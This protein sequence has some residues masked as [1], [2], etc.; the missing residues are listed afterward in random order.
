MA[1]RRTGNSNQADARE[2]EY[3]PFTQEAAARV[4]EEFGI[5]GK[6]DTLFKLVTETTHNYERYRRSPDHHQRKEALD[7]LRNAVGQAARVATK[8]ERTLVDSLE[9]NLLRRLGELL[10]YEGIEKLLGHYVGRQPVPPA[11]R[12]WEDYEERTK[13]DRSIHAARAGP[14]LLVELFK[15]MESAIGD[16]HTAPKSKGGR[17]IKHLYRH[18]VAADLARHYHWLFDDKRPTSTNDGHFAKFCLAVFYELECN[19]T[20][21]EASL[22][23]ILDDASTHLMPYRGPRSRRKAAARKDSAKPNPN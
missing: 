12:I 15:E 4:T 18:L 7:N 13:L 14:K 20:G 19:T 2:K 22:P 11:E 9:M 5:E 3:R 23:D 8:Y 21:F 6:E 17:P 16:L 1:G 10:T